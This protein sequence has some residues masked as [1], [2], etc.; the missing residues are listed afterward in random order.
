MVV[1]RGGAGLYDHRVSQ[2]AAILVFEVQ[3]HVCGEYHLGGHIPGP[4]ADK[5]LSRRLDE[6]I[7]A[8][9]GIIFHYVLDQVTGSVPEQGSIGAGI[10]VPHHLHT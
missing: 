2:R 6:H 10:D 3:F 8:H 9:A 7:A 1:V 4:A 5:H